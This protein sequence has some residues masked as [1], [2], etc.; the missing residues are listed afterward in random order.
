MASEQDEPYLTVSKLIELLQHEAKDARVFV[1]VDE[2]H[3]CLVGN[4]SAPLTG[5][6][7]Q[8]KQDNCV[9]LGRE[10]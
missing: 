1:A 10:R 7:K 6:I 9:I 5:L 2:G 4:T 8:V 3:G